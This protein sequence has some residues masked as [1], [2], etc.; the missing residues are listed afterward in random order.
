MVRLSCT[1]RL[2]ITFITFQTVLVLPNVTPTT[3]AVQH[4]RVWHTTGLGFFPFARRYWGNWKF[5][6]SPGV[7]EMFHFSPLSSIS[8]IFRYRCHGINPWRVS[9]FGNLRI[10]ACLTTPRSLSQSSTSFFA[11][12]RLDIHHVPFIAWHSMSSYFTHN[13]RIK[14]LPVKYSFFKEQNTNN[15]TLNLT[16]LSKV[17]EMSG[18]EPPTS[19]L[20]GQRSPSWATS[21]S[22]TFIT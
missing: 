1:I 14:L 19:A 20:Q 15:L 21:P 9:P 17:V 2:K 22:I 5:L 3:P 16:A 10:T 12:Q 7:T 8:Y 13:L 18:V 4:T 6:S 11:S